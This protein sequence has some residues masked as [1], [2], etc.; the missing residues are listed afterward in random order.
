MMK[1]ILKWCGI[2]LGAVLLL[3]A[4][5]VSVVYAASEVV[6]RRK[7]DVPLTA[8]TAPRDAAAVEEGR[9]LGTVRNATTVA[10]VSRISR[11]KEMTRT[12]AAGSSGMA[13]EPRRPAAAATT[14]MRPRRLP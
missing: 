4:V 10:P 6:L 3:A 5:A 11:R 9:R 14:I 8:F 1:R 2:L 12:H 13:A 7:N